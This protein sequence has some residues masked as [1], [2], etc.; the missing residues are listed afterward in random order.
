[1]SKRMGT[2]SF[3]YVGGIKVGMVKFLRSYAGISKFYDVIYRK[4]ARQTREDLAFLQWVIKKFARRPVQDLVDVGSGTGRIAIPLSKRFAV[5]GV[6]SSPQMLAVARK[7]KGAER[8]KWL[9]QNMRYLNLSSRCDALVC[10]FTAF[11]YLLSDGGV[12]RTLRNFHETLRPGGILVI[13]LHNTIDCLDR[14]SPTATEEYKYGD[15]KIQRNIVRKVED[16]MGAIW[17]HKEE[18][19][20]NGKHV[21]EMH[22]LRV[23]TA[24]EFRHDLVEAGFRSVR[25]FGDFKDRKE[26]LKGRGARLIFVAVKDERGRSSQLKELD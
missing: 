22:R 9:V 24:H 21:Q 15:L 10:L 16:S 3:L 12:R 13:D 19:R 2:E 11:N 4:R 17:S 5:V 26:R 7:K 8:V 1:S 20:I 18:T 14:F 6:D 25:L 23:F